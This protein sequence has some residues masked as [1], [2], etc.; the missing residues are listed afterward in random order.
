MTSQKKILANR[1]NAQNSTGPKTARGKAR[2]R[3]NAVKCG[4]YSKNRPLPGED[5]HAY[6]RLTRRLHERYA[7]SDPVEELIVDQILGHIWRIGRLE[8]AERAYLQKIEESRHHR[9]LRFNSAQQEPPK[10]NIACGSDTS[11]IRLVDNK[12]PSSFWRPC[13]K[14]IID[15]LG[16]TLL[17]ATIGPHETRPLAELNAERRAHLEEILWLQEEL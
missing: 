6:Q 2:S 10:E 8:R 16:C 3:Y 17:E 5:K 12:N 11:K 4:I 1:H 7:P 9:A 14:E 13:E 15:D